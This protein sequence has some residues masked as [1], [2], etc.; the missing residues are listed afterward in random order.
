MFDNISKE[1]GIYR[2]FCKSTGKNYI[3]QSKNVRARILDHFNRL[4]NGSDDSSLLQKDYDLYGEENFMPERLCFCSVEELNDME[5]LYISKYK[6]NDRAFGYNMS[7]GG[8]KGY[9]VTDDFKEKFLGDKNPFYGK[10]HSEENRKKMSEN[11]KGVKLSEETRKNMSDAKKGTN[12]GDKNP[13]KRPEVREKLRQLNL[14]KK[15]TSESK[16]KLSESLRKTYK[17]HPEIISKIVE[18][19]KGYK[20]NEETKRKISEARKKYWANKKLLNS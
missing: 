9:S 17:E 3:G 7:D 14:G 11:H 10:K 5:K 15:M 6:S 18:S 20:H 1:P 2:I 8:K 12:T 16:C 19:R 13:A 4:R